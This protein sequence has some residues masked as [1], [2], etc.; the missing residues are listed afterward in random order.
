MEWNE[1]QICGNE[2]H[3][4]IPVQLTAWHGN[5]TIVDFCAI[6]SFQ[7]QHNETKK[8]ENNLDQFKTQGHISREHFVFV[9]VVVQHSFLS[10][11]NCCLFI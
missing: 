10:H 1:K 8:N 5:S 2:N 3:F 9:V 4:K 6:L 11:L 7:S